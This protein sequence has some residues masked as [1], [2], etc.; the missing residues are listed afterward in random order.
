MA[1]DITGN[2]GTN[3]NNNNFLG[4]I[5]NEPLVI[6]TN[7]TERLRVDANG[8]VGIGTGHPNKALSVN[9]AIETAYEGIYFGGMFG[10]GGQRLLLWGRGKRKRFSRL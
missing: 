10:V 4:T 2:N 6:R 7:N 1:W 8:N 3:P 9:G 5:D